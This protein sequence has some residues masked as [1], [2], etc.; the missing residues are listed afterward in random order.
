VRDL[1]HV[2]YFYFDM[3]F[4]FDNIKNAASNYDMVK[5]H[6]TFNKERNYIYQRR[7]EKHIL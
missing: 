5:P 6:N 2:N 4:Y 7:N 3:N 1:T